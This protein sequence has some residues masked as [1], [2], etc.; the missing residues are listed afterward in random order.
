[1][2]SF[3]DLFRLEDCVAEKCPLY[4]KTFFSPLLLIGDFF[5]LFLNFGLYAISLFRF[6]IYLFILSLSLTGNMLFNFLLSKVAIQSSNRFV[7][8][9][10]LYQ[11]PSLASDHI[12]YFTTAMITFIILWRHQTISV[13]RIVLLQSFLLYVMCCR[14]YIGINWSS[15]IVLGALLGFGEALLFQVFFYYWIFPSLEGF[16]KRFEWIGISNELLHC[17]SKRRKK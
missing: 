10:S 12:V 11:M 4:V 15:E 17:E 14:V 1:M 16:L 8:C 2:S 3:G 7:D 9:G 6:E 13:F 5:P